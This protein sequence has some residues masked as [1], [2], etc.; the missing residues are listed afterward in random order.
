MPLD[1][2]IHSMLADICWALPA[3]YKIDLASF[4]LPNTQE[5][6]FALMRRLM[7]LTEKPEEERDAILERINEHF[8]PDATFTE[9][10]DLLESLRIL[11]LIYFREG[12]VDATHRD[13]IPVI[14]PAMLKR[15]AYY[16]LDDI[17]Y[18]TGGFY[19]R[20]KTVRSNLLFSGTLIEK[21]LYQYRKACIE[22]YCTF[23]CMDVLNLVAPDVHVRNRALWR[24]EKLGLGIKSSLPLGEDSLPFDPALLLHTEAFSDDDID[25]SLRNFFMQ[26]MQPITF[27]NGC[28]EQ[29]ALELANTVDYSYRKP[30]GESYVLADVQAISLLLMA[31]L[32]LPESIQALDLM[33]IDSE[34][35]CIADVDWAK[36]Q[37]YFIRNLI[38]KGYLVVPEEIQ[39]LLYPLKNQ[40]DAAE[41]KHL[42]DSIPVFYHAFQSK[43]MDISGIHFFKDTRFYLSHLHLL[44]RYSLDM[45]TPAVLLST[46]DT[47]MLSVSDAYQVKLAMLC[48]AMINDGFDI[49]GIYGNL[50]SKFSC[51]QTAN[52]LK[53]DVSSWKLFFDNQKMNVPRVVNILRLIDNH[54]QNRHDIQQRIV[55]SNVMKLSQLRDV[56]I[57]AINYYP[58]YLEELFEFLNAHLPDETKAVFFG[59]LTIRKNGK[60]ESFDPIW[61]EIFTVNM[62]LKKYISIFKVVN[63]FYPHEAHPYLLINPK[64][65]KPLLVE[66]REVRY[67]ISNMQ[68]RKLIDENYVTCLTAMSYVMPEILISCFALLIENRDARQY[69]YSREVFQNNIALHGLIRVICHLFSTP[70]TDALTDD[71][72]EKLC[73][74]GISNSEDNQ[75]YF[76]VLIKLLITS[77]NGVGNLSD[78]EI[79][80]LLDGSTMMPSEWICIVLRELSSLKGGKEAII[81]E[82]IEKIWFSK[83]EVLLNGELTEST[84]PDALVFYKKIIHM[85]PDLFERFSYFEGKNIVQFLLESSI[86]SIALSSLLRYLSKNFPNELKKMLHDLLLAP[87]NEVIRRP[88]PIMGFT[89]SQFVRNIQ[90]LTPFMLKQIKSLYHDF[91]TSLHLSQFQNAPDVVQV[92]HDQLP[93]WTVELFS[94]RLM[95]GQSQLEDYI[96][97]GEDP[98]GL[99]EYYAESAPIKFVSHLLDFYH[100]NTT[101]FNVV[102][103]LLLHITNFKI[104]TVIEAYLSSQ[105]DFNGLKKFI[106]ELRLRFPNIEPIVKRIY[107][108][109]HSAE[110]SMQLGEESLNDEND[111]N[112]SKRTEFFSLGGGSGFFKPSRLP[113]GPASAS[114]SVCSASTNERPP[115]IGEGSLAIDQ[116]HCPEASATLIREPGVEDHKVSSPVRVAIPIDADTANHNP[117]EELQPKSGS[118]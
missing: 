79:I 24:A 71:M 115:S 57:S 6:E 75:E 7:E 80:A 4:E 63:Q 68:N 102:C 35:D 5:L 18:C 33:C 98:A 87:S 47:I 78:S 27:I 73:K 39:D 12:I 44:R 105:T 14:S 3:E 54:D 50:A 82:S 107:T 22:E 83:L 116:N 64:T 23:L 40:S 36:V 92:I 42:A 67:E 118:R 29:L 21:V 77:S 86:S 20:V 56:I 45:I 89:G 61:V 46:I 32:E 94:K 91:I 34:T 103:N 65:R 70:L 15:S 88:A 48:L 26:R 111:E 108:D 55:S 85:Y 11:Y 90:I 81:K 8:G 9:K 17:L 84:K 49:K 110:A 101:L 109:E 69:I 2:Q 43:E 30:K 19:S 37:E 104:E 1:T 60:Q 97:H 66:M 28:L 41:Y 76:Q 93:K 10:S 52:P 74:N 53:L 51:H 38:G 112:D 59:E 62:H 114:S 113:G 58:E 99:V 72:I 16:I 100:T 106:D 13:S 117:L 31:A 95:G 25:E 96:L